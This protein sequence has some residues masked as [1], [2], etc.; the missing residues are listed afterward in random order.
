MEPSF[1]RGDI[2]LIKWEENMDIQAG[3]IVLLQI[4]TSMPIVHR[5]LSSQE[6]YVILI[7]Q[8]DD[9]YIYLTKSDNNVPNDRGLYD[10]IMQLDK[11]KMWIEKEFIKGKII[12]YVPWLGY[13]TIFLTDNPSV[14][15]VLL[16]L[17]VIII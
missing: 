14:K 3:D 1:N 10:G 16:A 13:T 6:V 7:I 11:K 12:G 8:S 15:W 5:V 9:E 17:T 2:V 4:P